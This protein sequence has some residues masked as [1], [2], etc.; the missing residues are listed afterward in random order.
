MPIR[1]SDQTRKI[2]LNALNMERLVEVMDRNYTDIDEAHDID[3]EKAVRYASRNRGSVRINTGRF[4][5]V[6]EHLD[7]VARAR[8]LKLP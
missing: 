2:L 6:K 4:Y 7:R 5:T 3:R 1:I 8:R